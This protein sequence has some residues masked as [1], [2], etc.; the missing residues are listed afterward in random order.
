MYCP[1]CFDQKLYLRPSGKGFLALNGKQMSTAIFLFNTERQDPSEILANLEEKIEEIFK[2]YK[3][4]NNVDKIEKFEVF[5]SEFDCDNGCAIPASSKIS[6]IGPLVERNA[7]KA[8][9]TK[10][11]EKYSLRLEL[12]DEKI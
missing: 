9:L 12:E 11:A 6:L 2:W 8:S 10:L 4:F 1:V 7:Y 5:S 3:G